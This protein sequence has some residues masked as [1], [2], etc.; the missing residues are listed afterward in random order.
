MVLNTLMLCLSDSFYQTLV[1]HS[2]F[3]FPK[4]KKTSVEFLTTQKKKGT[5]FYSKVKNVYQIIGVSD[6]SDIFSLL[7]HNIFD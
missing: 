1:L 2:F 3:F 5:Q 6:I 7:F 4:K